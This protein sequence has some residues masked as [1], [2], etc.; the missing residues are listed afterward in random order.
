MDV[1]FFE[2][3][4]A[5]KKPHLPGMFEKNVLKGSLAELGSQATLSTASVSSAS[6]TKEIEVD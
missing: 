6:G 4:R 1:P 5:L 2:Q 3:V